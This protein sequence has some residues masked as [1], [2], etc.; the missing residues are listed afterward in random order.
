MAF[1]LEFSSLTDTVVLL[2]MSLI[3]KLTTRTS[4]ERITVAAVFAAALLVV[5]L[6]VLR[7]CFTTPGSDTHVD[8]RWLTIWSI[9]EGAVAVCAAAAPAFAHMFRKHKSSTAA[10]YP[11]KRRG[12]SNGDSGHSEATLTSGQRRS[13][14]RDGALAVPPVTRPDRKAADEELSPTESPRVAAKKETDKYGYSF[15]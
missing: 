2:P 5:I 8:P 12:R 15:G 7:L 1:I 9:S 3:Q 10:S 14:A 6:A 4:F 11:S 13:L